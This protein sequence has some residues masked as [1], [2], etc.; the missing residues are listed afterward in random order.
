[1]QPVGDQL[2]EAAAVGLEIAHL[3]GKGVVE[4]D[5]EIRGG[6]DSERSGLV[7]GLRES[8]GIRLG[9]EGCGV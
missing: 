3:G 9:I 2:E 6:E 4:E 5:L 1:V 8:P 7:V